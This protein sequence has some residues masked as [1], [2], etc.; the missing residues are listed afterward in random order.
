MCVIVTLVGCDVEKGPQV[1]KIDPSGQSVGYKAVAAGS[2]D[3]EA[4]TQLEKQFKKTE[5]NWSQKEAVETAIKVLQAV[6]NSDFKS[7][8]IEVGF[9]SVENPLFRKLKQSEIESV[10]ADM[11]DAL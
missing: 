3:Q 1:Y 8:D 2:K 9:A 6:V 4:I 10:L 7:N 11:Q 5:G